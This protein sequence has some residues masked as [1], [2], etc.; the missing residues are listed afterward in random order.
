MPEAIDNKGAYFLNIL[1][2]IFITAY[3]KKGRIKPNGE[4]YKLYDNMV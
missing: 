1:S 3:Y 4:A 2:M